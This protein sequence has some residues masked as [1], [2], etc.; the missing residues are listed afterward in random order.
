MSVVLSILNA[1]SKPS[2]QVV[3][4]YCDNAMFKLGRRMGIRARSALISAVFRKAMALDMS[5]ANAGQLQVFY[6]CYVSFASFSSFSILK[7]YCITHIRRKLR[8][9]VLDLNRFNYGFWFLS[10]WRL[11]SLFMMFSYFSIK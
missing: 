11:L 9:H 10:D 6:L 5:S 2:K 3:A 1:N 7:T 4:N 8:P